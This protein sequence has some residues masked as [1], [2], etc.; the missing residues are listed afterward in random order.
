MNTID[1]IE[2]RLHALADGGDRVDATDL[3]DRAA[4][5][6]SGHRPHRR[7]SLAAA[8][9]VLATAVSA[10]ALWV[11]SRD[12]GTI[13][14]Q[15][16]SV[17]QGSLPPITLPVDGVMSSVLV[18]E[19]RI[20]VAATTDDEP[21]RRTRL[22]QFD[23]SDGSLRG[24]AHSDDATGGWAGTAVG[25]SATDRHLWMAVHTAS[26]Y[27][28]AR[29]E[30]IDPGGVLVAVDPDT[31]D[32]V[33][34]GLGFVRARPAIASFGDQLA[35]AD[36]SGLQLVRDA[37]TD[38]SL[39]P[40]ASDLP[41]TIGG[42]AVFV[43]L[44]RLRGPGSDVGD[45]TPIEALHF[46]ERGL[47][48][49]DGDRLLRIDPATGTLIAATSVDEAADGP[50]IRPIWWFD[51][52]EPLAGAAHNALLGA[53]LEMP[54]AVITR[55]DLPVVD[56]LDGPQARQAPLLHGNPPADPRTGKGTYDTA[57]GARTSLVDELGVETALV[58]RVAG[59][60]WLAVQRGPSPMERRITFIEL[61]NAARPPT[62]SGRLTL[63]GKPTAGTVWIERGDAK[64]EPGVVGDDGRFELR[65]RPGT[66]RM[67]GATSDPDASC[68]SIEPLSVASTRQEVE[69]TC[70]RRSAP[71]GSTGQVRIR[72]QP[73]GGRFTEGFEI[74]IKVTW[75]DSGQEL[76]R[77]LWSDVVKT[78]QPTTIDEW[79]DAILAVP[80]PAGVEVE[81]SAGVS[82]GQGPPPSVPNLDTQLPC[83]LPL[84]VEAGRTAEV[85]V[86]FDSA[87]D[88]LRK[89]ASG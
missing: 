71:T 11:T 70:T 9:I 50:M 34:N 7:T 54:G 47:W 45:S 2:R 62:V 48:G 77:G 39:S 33:F 69:L 44:P 17:E 13:D 86:R 15:T 67:K 1:T 68:T 36:D 14:V 3:F 12:D 37:I 66:Y 24:E 57:T 64:Y 73:V 18:T 16:P 6:A 26:S 31:L 46:D 65:V 51:S 21:P 28:G 75:A 87:A 81:I 52:T 5:E 42:F 38:V 79:Y 55:V 89:T 19:D 84:T 40:D 61:P 72:L 63:D 49:W 80:V 32:S 74:G 76:Y 88:C 56:Q 4:A 8:A 41:K 59:G 83:R 85:E 23:R 29:G 43:P 20:W 53:E 58:R 78:R 30:R 60:D 35:V 27:R 25:L 82:I 10:T 22:F